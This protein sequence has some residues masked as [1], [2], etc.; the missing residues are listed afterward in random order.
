MIGSIATCL[1]LARDGEWAMI[2]YLAK[3][4]WHGLDLKFAGLAE[5]GL[6][7]ER[8]IFY[9][10]SSGPILERVL[11]ALPIAPSDKALDIGCGKGG[12]ILTLAK[13]PF[14]RVDGVEL[15]EELISVARENL[16]RMGVRNSVIHHSD[17]AV[18]KDYDDYT[19]I[20]MYHPFL[21]VVMSAAMKHI[22][23]S[24]QVRPRKITLIYRNPVCH[25][26]VIEAGF[27]KTAEFPGPDHP[28]F[29]YT[30][31]PVTER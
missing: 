24:M 25:S 19:F 31:D 7:A 16:R 18:F 15:S 29:A 14:A 28:T 26:E 13:Y 2:V 6:S 4:K 5:L 21:P 11:N 10:D 3:T 22:T 30:A 9:A 1:R 8:S 17:A 20:Y 23:Q 12:A 27:R